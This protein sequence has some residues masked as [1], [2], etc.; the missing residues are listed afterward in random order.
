[1]SAGP[2]S[3]R[4]PVP[5]RPVASRAPRQRS[6]LEVRWRQ[7]RNAP[8]PVTRAIAANLLAAVVLAVPLLGY[9]L[10]V[11]GGT[12]LPGGDLRTAAVGAYVV[13]VLLVGSIL[14]Y[15]WVPLPTGA[16]GVRRRTAWSAALGA[17]AA[18]PVAYIVLVVVFQILEPLL[19]R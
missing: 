8:P 13:A 9:D 14:T 17:F 1:M 16:S 18:V 11:S 3:E 4:P 2:T 6:L 5:A 7:W 12:T 15:L 10:A 19:L